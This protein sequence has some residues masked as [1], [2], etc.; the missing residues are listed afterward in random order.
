MRVK[1]G[2]DQGLFIGSGNEEVT[3]DAFSA[4]VEADAS[5]QQAQG[6]RRT[7]EVG[8]ASTGHSLL[9]LRFSDAIRL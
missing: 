9:R 3:F 8:L 2:K 1:Y 7:E 5:Q 4:V 6:G